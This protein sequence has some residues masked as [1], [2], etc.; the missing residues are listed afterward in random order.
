MWQEIYINNVQRNVYSNELA[1]NVYS[2]LLLLLFLYVCLIVLT[3]YPILLTCQ[4]HTDYTVSAHDIL[5]F[6][7]CSV[8]FVRCTDNNQQLDVF[9]V[10][11]VV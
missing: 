4:M 11:S 9:I 5:I 7:K 1:V 6:E 2:I 3:Y 8:V 10:L